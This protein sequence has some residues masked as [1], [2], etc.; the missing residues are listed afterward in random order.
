MQDLIFIKFL[1]ANTLQL[2]STN[3][4]ELKLNDT[5]AIKNNSN[6]LHINK[7]DRHFEIINDPINVDNGKIRLKFD[8]YDSC[9]FSLTTGLSVRTEVLTDNVTITKTSYPQSS[10]PGE[11]PNDPTPNFGAKTWSILCAPN[12]GIAIKTTNPTG[13]MIDYKSTGF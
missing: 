2:S 8:T 4:L 7:Y 10:L 9:L 12:G 6:G 13:I 5:G 3:K 11:D 1:E